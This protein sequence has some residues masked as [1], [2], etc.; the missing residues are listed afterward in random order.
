MNPTT[1]MLEQRMAALEG[2]VAALAVAF[3]PGRVRLRHPELGRPGDN[4]VTSTDLYG[5][6]WNLFANTL[7]GPGHRGALRRSRRIRK[8]S[9]SATDDAH[10]RL[11]CRDPAQSASSR[12]S[13]S[14]KWPTIG[15]KLG[16]PLIMDNTA[17]PIICRPV[18]SWRGDRRLFDHQIYRRPWHL[19]RRRH[20]RWRQL[21]LGEAHA[22][23]FPALEPAG[24]LLSRR[25]LDRGREAARPDRLYHQGARH[26]AARSR[27]VDEP[28]QR[29]PVHPGPRDPAAADARALPERRRRSRTISTA[30]R[31]VTKVIHPSLST[32]E[33]KRRADTYLKGGYGGLV[34]FEL[35]GGAR[36]GRGASSM[37]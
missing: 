31:Q 8:L 33:D 37:C 22:E 10:P 30:I 16:V 21:R 32:G 7:P 26:P 2:G 34:G 9:A 20:R 14:A 6:T 1:A 15:R 17:A 4:I 13:R 12:S 19:D 29:L 27:R 3:G 28:V 24:P 35:K 18:R 23:R 36:G 5:G 11:L 25:G